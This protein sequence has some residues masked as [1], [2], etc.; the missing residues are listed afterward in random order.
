[1]ELF[2][3]SRHRRGSGTAAEEGRGGGVGTRGRWDSRVVNCVNVG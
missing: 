1:M 3:P 2:L